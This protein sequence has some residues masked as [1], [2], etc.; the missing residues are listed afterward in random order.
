MPSASL[1]SRSTP[2]CSTPPWRFSCC[3][4]P[5]WPG[6]IGAVP[7]V[8]EA[9]A[10]GTIVANIFFLGVTH[11]AVLAAVI[12]G[13]RR[14]LVVGHQ[15]RPPAR[16][17][18]ARHARPARPARGSVL[19]VIPDLVSGIVGEGQ[20]LLADYSGGIEGLNVVGALGVGIVASGCSLALV[21][22][23]PLLK[24][25]SDD[26]VA[27]R[28][29]GRPDARVAHRVAAPVENFEGELAVV[30]SAEPLI[31]LREEK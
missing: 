13:A 26:D 15:G 17:R 21:S 27:R 7:G 18:Q 1:A 12:G 5:P 14:H 8:L 16:R 24:A 11:G 20:E 10:D 29:V 23:L 4:S 22:F 9:P 28:P 25:P 19:V 2:A 3:C 31:D 6:A 30:T